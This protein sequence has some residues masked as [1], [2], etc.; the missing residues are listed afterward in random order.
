MPE[1]IICDERVGRAWRGARKRGLPLFLAVCCLLPISVRAAVR[2]C[3]FSGS[4]CNAPS[5]NSP[6]AVPDAQFA[7]GDFDGDR[8]PDLATV[9]MGRFNSLHSRYWISFQLSKGRMQTIGVTG[10][11]GGLV[12]LARDVNG[13]RALDLVLVTAWRHQLV[14]VLLN[15]GE[16]NFAAAD[17]TLFQI[18]TASSTAHV[19]TAPSLTGDR[20][21]LSLPYSTLAGQ[22]RKTLPPRE[23]ERT[24]SRAPDLALILF[25]PAFSGRAPPRSSLH[26]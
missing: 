12:L 25:A 17:A 13:D 21:V 6:I 3:D 24:S 1:A 7:I 9:E 5:Q 2:G 15:D 20:T 26:V 19:G 23:S 4:T 11:A 22:Q 18:H 16:G 8:K 14:A 10:P